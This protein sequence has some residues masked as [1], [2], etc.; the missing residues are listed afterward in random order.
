[1][2]EDLKE[3]R[4]EDGWE[5]MF[6]SERTASDKGCNVEEFLC[7]RDVKESRGLELSERGPQ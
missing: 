3:V 2:G 7:A 6:S 4:D 1:M 5:R